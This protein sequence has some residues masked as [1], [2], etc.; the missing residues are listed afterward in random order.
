M[1]PDTREGA[2]RFSIL[3]PVWNTDA[4]MFEAMVESVVVQTFGRWELILSDDA[5]DAPWMRELLER[6]EARDPRIRVIR[7]GDNGGIAAATNSALAEATGEYVALLDHDDVLYPKALA[8]MSEAIDEE[9]TADYLYSDEDKLD[10]LGRRHDPF[11]K[12]AWSPDRFK[13]QMYTCH[14]S[15]LRRSVVEAVGGLRDGFEAA[16]DWDLVLR[17]VEQARQIV[18]VPKVLYGWRAHVGSTAA[19]LGAKPHAVASQVR[20]VQ[21][22][23][24]RTGFPATIEPHPALPGRLQLRPDLDDEPLVSIIMPTAG[25]TRRV[26]GEDICLVSRAVRSVVEGCS[27]TNVEFVIVHDSSTPPEVLEDLRETC[28]SRLRLLRWVPEFN[29]S[30]QC[31]L[32]AVHAEGEH[33]LLLNDDV[34]VITPDFIEQLL[35]FST[36]RGVGA[37]GAKLL[38]AD[39]RVQHAGVVL[40]AVGLPCHTLHGFPA[41]HE[42]YFDQALIPVNLVA[43]TGACLMTRRSVFFEVGGLSQLLPN[44]FNDIDYCL[45]VVDEGLRITL[46]SQA[47]LWHYESMSRDN[48]VQEYEVQRLVDLWQHR[49]PVDP[50]YNPNLYPGVNF[51]PPWRTATEAAV[52]EPLTAQQRA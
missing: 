28:G 48:T 21:E 45:K 2:P 52:H 44:N 10:E 34:E 12:P 4:V 22:H 9:P 1:H 36:D 43:V 42:G 50:L 29:F 27:Y 7:R 32:G 35:M 20:A 18:H 41:D 47:R 31:N 3:V 26:R 25:T 23:L 30:A 39:D 13:V 46:N 14:F 15:V 17:V 24:D 33:L 16:Q 11:F 40:S 5:S 19:D 38:Y 6:A 51:V 8:A 37:V 49:F